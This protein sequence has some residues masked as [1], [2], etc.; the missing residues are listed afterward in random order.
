[1]SETKTYYP[2]KSFDDALENFAD[3]CLKNEWNFPGITAEQLK[4]DAEAQQQERREHDKAEREFNALHE[5]FGV[6]QE[7]RH[8][9]FSKSISAARKL[10]SG[11]KAVMAQL[12]KMKLHDKPRKGVEDSSVLPNP[13][14]KK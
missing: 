13:E 11:D 2:P 9:R 6:N 1:M 3:L 10:F 7:L 4:K 14:E 5:N 12:D 8:E